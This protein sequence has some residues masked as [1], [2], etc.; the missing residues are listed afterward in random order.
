[1]DSI[2]IEN[3]VST[4]LKMADWHRID[5]G[6]A[7]RVSLL[8]VAMGKRLG[9]TAEQ[10]RMLRYA[11]RLHDLGRVGVDNSILSKTSSLTKSQRAAVESHS[12]IGH[13]MLSESGLP[14]EIVETVLYHHEHFDGSGYPNG[15]AGESIPLF[16][17]IVCIADTYDGI[18]SERPYHRSR[19]TEVALDHMHKLIA[20]FD[21]KL[22]A[23]FL[24]VLRDDGGIA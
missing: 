14:A 8:S 21:P 13:E 18:L 6:H 5:A 10:L 7:D 3:F 20:W 22:F 17:R 19:V 15:L 2:S 16:A 12:T 4:L 1:M 23:I 24:S 9:L 11:T